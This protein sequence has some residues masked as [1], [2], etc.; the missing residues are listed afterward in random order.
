M[1]DTRR[2]ITPEEIPAPNRIFLF[3]SCTGSLEYPGTEKAIREVLGRLS[4]EVVMSPDQT[5]CSGYMLTCNAILPNLSLAATARNM[6]VAESMGL[7]VYV[8]CNGCFGYNTELTHILKTKPTARQEADKLIRPMG[9]H[10]E[11]T[12]RIYHIQELLYRLK[13]ELFQQVIRPLDGIRVAVHYGCHY[14]S[15][16]YGIL[17]DTD[18]PTFLEEIIE[19][20]GG[21]PVFYRERRSCC[22]AAVGRGFTH[23]EE[24]S[25]PH[26]RKKLLS[27]KEAG[28]DVIVT[29]CPGCNVQLDREQPVLAERGWGEINIPVIDFSQLA[30]LCLG[31]SPRELGF[32]AN[33]VSLKDLL[34]KIGWEE[35]AV[36]EPQ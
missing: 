1:E 26:V 29:V 11:G 23:R 21:V 14:L 35:K 31:V 12:A 33:T 20:L 30:A 34:K 4:I 24:I 8:F 2:R 19:G 3:R 7:D 17:D 16:K 22:G 15:K 36:D 32:A 10:Y 9:W 18:Y 5:C 27:V 13:D 6:A 28:A 25:L